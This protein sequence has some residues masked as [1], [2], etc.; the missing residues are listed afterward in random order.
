MQNLNQKLLP[1]TA[2][3]VEE[4]KAGKRK[5]FSVFGYFLLMISKT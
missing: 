1:Q 5:G 4:A 3:Q 2:G